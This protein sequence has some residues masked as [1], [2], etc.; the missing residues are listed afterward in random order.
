MDKTGYDVFISYSRQDYVDQQGNVIEGNIVSKIKDALTRNGIRFWFDEEGIYSGERFLEVIVKNIRSARIF[1]FISTRNS[2]FVS[3]WTSKE[4]NTAFLEDKKIIPVR[5]DDSPYRDSIKLLLSDIDEIDC[6]T[7]Q[8][9]GFDR[10]IAAIKEH[11][12]QIKEQEQLACKIT[13]ARQTIDILTQSRSTLRQKIAHLRGELKAICADYDNNQAHIARMTEF[14]RSNNIP[15][16]M[17]LTAD[18]NY[19]CDADSLLSQNRELNKNISELQAKLTNAERRVKEV[20]EDKNNELDIQ[21]SN[22]KKCKSELDTL[23]QCVVSLNDRIYSQTTELSELRK[24][25]YKLLKE[26]ENHDQLT[27][28][29]NILRQIKEQLST[30]LETKTAINKQQKRHFV[31]VLI[32]ACVL[33]FTTIMFLIAFISANDDFESYQQALWKAQNKNIELT[34]ASDKVF[35]VSHAIATNIKIRNGADNANGENKRI[36]SDNTTYLFVSVDI[37]TNEDIRNKTVYMNLITPSGLS[38]TDSS[39]N[40][41][42]LELDGL[43][44]SKYTLTDIEFPGWGNE[45]KG[46]WKAGYYTI[47]IWMDNNCIGTKLFK[48]YPHD[49]SYHSSGDNNTVKGNN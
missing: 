6:Y 18:D 11:T 32:S 20:L 26:T 44:F 8:A 42:T 13:E 14:L 31:I 43:S 12:M 30:S 2:N 9:K 25:N 48:I 16:D 37:I 45:N 47:E 24:I 34:S 35:G 49:G 29:V 39:P 17:T 27:S 36:F 19:S 10:M 40:N 1:L 4:L 7:N 15:V 3:K 28:E 33:F 41:H 38:T 46:F 23:K 22:L 21:E 5:C